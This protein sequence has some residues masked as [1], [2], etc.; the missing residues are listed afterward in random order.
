MF[1]WRRKPKGLV[2]LDIGSSSIKAVELGKRGDEY[3]LVSFAIAPLGTDVVVD[4]IVRDRDLVSQTITKMFTDS[5]IK[6][7]SVAASVSGHS[8]IVKKITVEANNEDELASAIPYEAQQQIQLDMEDIKLS[9]QV[10][11][12]ASSSAFDVLL[13]AVKREKV[14]NYTD[15]LQQARAVPVVIDIDAFALGNAFEVNYEPHPNLVVAL[16][17]IGASTMN[18]SIIR[19]GVPLFTRDVSVGGNLYTDALQKEFGLSFADAESLKEGRQFGDVKVER[20]SAHIRSVSEILLLEIQKTLDFFR[21]NATGEAIQNIYLAGG[22]AR[23]EGLA[24][25]LRQDL[26]A[27]VEIIDPFRKVKIDPTRF[28]LDYV[29]ELRPRMAVAVGLALRAFDPQ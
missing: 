14:A 9:Y 6:T 29:G 17:N 5:G 13:A 8:V 12:A 27:P 23:V 16:L 18:I 19:G 4:G 25:L 22:S 26:N 15:V 2:G 10:L 20:R 21:Q 24:D 7:R 1:G 11:G 3:D 28:D